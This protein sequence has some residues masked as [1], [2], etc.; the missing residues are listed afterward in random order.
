M[1]HVIT[2]APSVPFALTRL[3]VIMSP[4]PGNAQE[5]EGV[6]NPGTGRDRSGTLYLLP[7]LV[8]AGN[9]SRIGLAEVLVEDGA[10]KSVRRK[11]IALAPDRGWERGTQNA[12]TEDPRVTWVEGLGLHIMVYVAYGPLGPRPAVAVSDDLLS[13]RRLG[14]LHFEYEHELDAD[15]NLFTNKD[16]VFFPEIVPDPQGRPSYAVLHRP[17]WDL[18][19]IREG[20]GLHLPLQVTDERPSIWISYVDAAAVQADVSA[21]VRVRCHRE[22]A[23]PQFEWEHTKIGAGPAPLRIDEGWLLIHHGVA[24]AMVGSPLLPQQNV[25]YSAGA[26]ILSADDPSRVIARTAEPLLVPETVDEVGGT[27]PRVVFP[28]AIETIEGAAFVF[29][30][31]A[32]SKIGVA[33]LTR[34]N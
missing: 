21:L 18:G 27:V 30:G 23:N 7:R 34:T 20:E 24:G 19:M 8:A 17:T 2:G 6:L 5:V 1:N 28:T 26:M 29:Y 25:T 32:D 31:M 9:I 13:W 4:E 11:G 33:R 10:P 15:L 14:P 22:V 3:G 12:G 16:V